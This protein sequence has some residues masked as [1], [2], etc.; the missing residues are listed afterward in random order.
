MAKLTLPIVIDSGETVLE[1]VQRVLDSTY[2]GRSLREWADRI[3]KP[4]TKGDKMRSMTDE[5]LAEWLDDICKSAY[6]EGYTKG[7]GEPLMSPYPSTA[8]EWITWMK[9]EAGE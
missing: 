3:S 4:R 5:E 9:Q 2:K 1:L 8:S 6:D 7:T